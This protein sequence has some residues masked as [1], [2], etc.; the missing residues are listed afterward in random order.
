MRERHTAPPLPVERDSALAAGVVKERGWQEWAR[1][2]RWQIAPEPVVLNRSFGARV[3]GH[4]VRVVSGRGGVG[5]D[6]GGD[7]DASAG[8][9]A[10]G[11]FGG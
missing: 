7:G 9:G 11:C 1:G 4:V 2:A 3:G 5:V 10:W 6:E 8:L